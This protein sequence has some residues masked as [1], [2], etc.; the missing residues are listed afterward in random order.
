[1]VMLFTLCFLIAV[2]TYVRVQASSMTPRGQALRRVCNVTAA[3]SITMLA[4]SSVAQAF[5]PLPT[6]APIGVVSSAITRNEAQT[7]G[8]SCVVG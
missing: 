1:M 3:V 8:S 6:L 7:S 4:V 2:L 5:A